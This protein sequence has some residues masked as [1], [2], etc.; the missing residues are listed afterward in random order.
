METLPGERWTFLGFSYK[1]GA[2]D[3]SEISAKKLKGKMKRKSRALLRWKDRKKLSG[4]K[5]AKAFVNIFNRRLFDNSVET[6]LTWSLWYFPIIN[7]TKT[8][9]EI[10]LYSQ[11]CI[12]YIAT[13]KRGKKRFDF[14]YADIKNLGYKSLVHEYYRIAEETKKSRQDQTIND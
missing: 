3:I 2:I 5:A 14:R 13:E 7:T 12:R 6:E 11:E 8:L 9:K 10:D 1:D 4:V